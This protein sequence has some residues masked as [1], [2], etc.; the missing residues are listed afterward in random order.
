[1]RLTVQ[2]LSAL[3]IGYYAKPF[4]LSSRFWLLNKGLINVGERQFRNPV[5]LAKELHPAFNTGE[6]SSLV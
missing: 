6:Y 1:M 3:L 5:Y 2:I 4:E